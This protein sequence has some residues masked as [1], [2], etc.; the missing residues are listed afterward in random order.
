MW[1]AMYVVRGRQA[2]FGAVN[3]WC[4]M[5]KIEVKINRMG[6]C[7]ERADTVLRSCQPLPQNPTSS[8][9]LN[10]ENP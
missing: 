10:H 1:N 9:T 3:L 2:I 6:G 4:S 7:T 8:R 5:N